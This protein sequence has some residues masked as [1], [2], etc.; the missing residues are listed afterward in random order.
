MLPKEIKKLIQTKEIN[1][2]KV[3]GTDRF[4]F[5]LGVYCVCL[6]ES[7]FPRVF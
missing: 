5:F 6:V 4:D 1:K 7:L 3:N 2:K